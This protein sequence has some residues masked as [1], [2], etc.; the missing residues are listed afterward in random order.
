MYFVNEWSD[1]HYDCY[2]F[3]GSWYFTIDLLHWVI[4]EQISYSNLDFKVEVYSHE[5]DH[6]GF[7]E[8][9]VSIT[10]LYLPVDETNCAVVISCCSHC[11]F[12]Q[13]FILFT[14]L[15][16]F[17]PDSLSSWILY[18]TILNAYFIMAAKC[19]NCFNFDSFVY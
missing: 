4:A 5:V 2:S 17:T 8:I 7:I 10:C 14:K 12:G 6:Y 3:D 18:L 9:S 1:C 15:F 16:N 13:T 19:E 11:Y